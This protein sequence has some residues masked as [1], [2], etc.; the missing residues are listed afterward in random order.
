MNGM[1]LA[2]KIKELRLERSWSQS[3]LAVVASLSL[4]TVQRVEL[5]GKCSKE[6]LLSLASAF[7]IDVR[8]LTDLIPN[9]G[10]MISILGYNLSTSWL[11]SNRSVLIGIIIMMPAVYFVSANILKYG[12]GISFLAEPLDVFYLN[13]DILKIFNFISPIIFLGGLAL[14]FLLNIMVLLSINVSIKSGKI[15]STISITPKIANLIIVITCMLFTVT[16]LFYV[17][18][19]N[20]MIRYH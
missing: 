20:F 19:E 2:N 17:I 10:S 18:G 11:D 15:H 16:L 1:L 13:T 8:E 14:A 5:S 9:T 12:F 7:D 6:S 4:R 3:Q